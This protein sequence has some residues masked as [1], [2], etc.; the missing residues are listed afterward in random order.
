MEFDTHA[1][2]TEP[3]SRFLSGPLLVRTANR[4]LKRG[5]DAPAPAGPTEAELLT[6]IRDELRGRP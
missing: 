3:A 1:E 5:E 6:E 4:M 2:A